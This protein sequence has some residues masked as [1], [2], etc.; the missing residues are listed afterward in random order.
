MMILKRNIDILKYLMSI[1]TIM[2]YIGY[3]YESSILRCVVPV[4]LIILICT[5]LSF[6]LVK[7]SSISK[8][9]W[10]RYSY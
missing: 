4:L 9:K 3:S 8:F 7:I 1:M 2:R 5:I 6:I 10:I